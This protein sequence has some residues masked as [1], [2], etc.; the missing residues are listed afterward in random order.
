LAAARMGE[1][2]SL[3]VRNMSFC[4]DVSSYGVYSRFERDE[5]KPGQEVLL[6]AEI[7]N[8][9]SESTA[10]GYHTA[11]ASSYRIFDSRGQQVDEQQFALTEE[12]CQNARQDFFIR[13]FLW[14]PKRAYDGKYTLQL[15]I[16]DTL[17]KKIGQASIEFTIKE[18]PAR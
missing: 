5:F 10:K 6:Y 11:L 15:S 9:K 14:M 4:T 3:V 18:A 13:Y 17:N 1:S 2:G 7:E 16:E 8:F 12:H